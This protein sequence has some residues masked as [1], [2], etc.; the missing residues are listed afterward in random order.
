MQYFK[1]LIQLLLLSSVMFVSTAQAENKK[2]AENKMITHFIVVWLKDPANAEKRAE[3]VKIS[4]T[5]NDL[6]NIVHRHVGVVKPSDRM[7]VDDTF[8]VAISATFK[9]KAALQ[10]YLSHPKHKKA[11]AAIKPLVNRVVAYDLVSP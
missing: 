10:A 8:D 4:E 5:L 3:F 9:N 6:P 1:T 11:L 2:A 7:I